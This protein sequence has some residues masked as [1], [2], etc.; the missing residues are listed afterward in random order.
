MSGEVIKEPLLRVSF[1]R[2][3][4]NITDTPLQFVL[5]ELGAIVEKI[6]ED[7]RLEVATAQRIWV[8]IETE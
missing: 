1:D 5:H 2:S 4:L 3:S 7:L 6:P 8:T